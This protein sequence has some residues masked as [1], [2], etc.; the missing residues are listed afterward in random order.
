M[1]RL[2][3]LLLVCSSLV[4]AQAT[5]TSPQSPLVAALVRDVQRRDAAAVEQFW[6]TVAA[7]K[8]PLVDPIPSDPKHVLAT[9]L[10]RGSNDTRD[11]A[12]WRYPAI[13]SPSAGAA[14]SPTDSSRRSN[15]SR[16]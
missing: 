1:T 14:R 4:L 3:I 5:D 9:F 8:T 2:A 10:F 15:G 12:M 7:R 11:V 16:A 6:K 13:M